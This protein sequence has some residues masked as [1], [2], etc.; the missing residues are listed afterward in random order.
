MSLSEMLSD[1][2]FFG[3]TD[4]SYA[5]IVDPTGR[6]L[7]HPLLPSPA[8]ANSD[9]IFLQAT[10]LETAPEAKDVIQSMLRCCYSI[11]LSHSLIGFAS[12]TEVKAAMQRSLHVESSPVVTV[13]SKDPVH[14]Q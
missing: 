1:V 10:T 7:I 6:L 12:V 9:P 13:V 8:T 5:F 2:T 14:T 4:S 11:K 3:R